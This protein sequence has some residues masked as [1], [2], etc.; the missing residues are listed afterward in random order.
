M[1]G[2][3]V[4]DGENSVFDN[5]SPIPEKE[6]TKVFEPVLNGAASIR[7][8]KEFTQNATNK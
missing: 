3:S 8:S 2:K 5:I 6:K 1:M 7:V 4:L